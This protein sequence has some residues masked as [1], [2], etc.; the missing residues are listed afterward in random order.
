MASTDILLQN[1]LA[2]VKDLEFD[3]FDC[4]GQASWP[5]HPPNLAFIITD[6]VTP[7]YEEDCFLSFGGGGGGGFR[8]NSFPGKKKQTYNAQRS[9]GYISC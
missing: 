3:S 2:G 7:L 5:P 8:K 1:S 9:Q 4:Q 6:R